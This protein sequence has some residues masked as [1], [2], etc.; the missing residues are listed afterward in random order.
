MPTSLA[1]PSVLPLVL[2][3]GG[4]ALL[5]LLLAFALRRRQRALSR[6]LV[7]LAAIAALAGAAELSAW[8]RLVDSDH[9]NHTLASRRWFERH[10]GPLN[11]L[12][13]RDREHVG[14]VTDADPLIFF[15]GD[16]FTAGQGVERAADRFADRVAALLGP[17]ARAVVVAQCGWNSS[18]ELAAI[19]GMAAALGRWPDVIVL[20]W[21]P[22]DLL[23]QRLLAG[24]DEPFPLPEAPW[25]RAAPLTG[26]SYLLDALTWRLFRAAELGELSRRHGRTLREAFADDAIRARHRAVLAAMGGLA[27]RHGSRFL[28]LTFPDLMALE[29]SQAFTRAAAEDLRAAGAEVIDLGPRLA[30]RDPSLLRAGLRDAHPGELVHEEVAL[31]L[32]ER[33]RPAS[34]AAGAR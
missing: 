3:A 9:V 26:S 15:V 19:E 4:A 32:V 10:W 18:D 12:G 2:G 28:A 30:G 29:A 14:A 13:F 25:G 24:R 8:A 27:A 20:A 17:P 21:V 33:L 23:D 16:S 31:L 5:G 22:N 11:S 1:T 34:G 6:V 7:A